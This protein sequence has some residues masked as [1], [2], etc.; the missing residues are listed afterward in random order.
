MLTC[1][2]SL[3]ST[4]ALSASVS[5]LAHKH[6]S[7]A[8]LVPWLQ[9]HPHSLPQH[10]EPE[11]T[12]PL[13]AGRGFLWAS[14]EYSGTGEP[15]TETRAWDE[16]ESGDCLTGTSTW[17]GTRDRTHSDFTCLTPCGPQ[18]EPAWDTRVGKANHIHAAPESLPLKFIDTEAHRLKESPKRVRLERKCVAPSDS[19]RLRARAPPR[20]LQDAPRQLQ[21]ADAGSKL[22]AITY[23]KKREQRSGSPPCG[24]GSPGRLHEAISAQPCLSRSPTSTRALPRGPASHSPA[25]L[26]SSCP[27]VRPPHLPAPAASSPPGLSS[28][29]GRTGKGGNG[30][31]NAPCCSL[32]TSFMLSLS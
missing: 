1:Y 28:S 5:L 30:D 3:E 16:Q 20:G 22:D 6:F 11:R 18:G 23:P 7:D 12:R 10:M 31:T 19:L 27:P 14:A 25:L 24:L 32:L 15:N 8:H 26:L 2:Y 13:P 29:L 17:A 9:P 21:E 4:P